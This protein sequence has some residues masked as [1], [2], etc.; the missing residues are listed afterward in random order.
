MHSMDTVKTR[1]QGQLTSRHVKYSGLSQAFRTILR[2]EGVRGL[3]GGFA[4][5]AIGSLVSTTVY[6]GVYEAVKRKFI[7]DGYNPTGTYLFAGAVADVAASVL[8]VPSEVLKT[9]LQ[10]QGHYNNPHSLSAHNYRGTWDALTSILKKRGVRGVYYG[11]G[12]TLLRDVP[13]VSIQFAIYETMKT[14]FITTQ[15]GGDPTQLTTLHDITSGGVA[16]VVAGAVTTPLDVI[17]T[18]LQTQKRSSTARASFLAD[19]PVIDVSIPHASASPELASAATTSTSSTATTSSLAG[20]SIH[21]R[22]PT[23]APL[24]A[25]AA[26]ASSSTLSSAA[27]GLST[28]AKTVASTAAAHAASHSHGHAAYYDGVLSAG[29]GIYGRSGV[30]G[31]FSGI[32]PRM[33]WTGM[34]STIMFV[35]FEFAMDLTRRKDDDDSYIR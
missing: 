26:T 34:Q 31:L 23:V 28:A 27:T 8:Y 3:Y 10:L 19:A 24:S 1:L 30:S 15:C 13:F 4:S 29:L 9:R 35:L 20:S 16:G 2:E 6:F 14:H 12:A 22:A 17:K 32:G 25:G 5:A 33:L 7:G 11:W 18:Y 21:K